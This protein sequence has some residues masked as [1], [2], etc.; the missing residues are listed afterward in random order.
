[1]AITPAE[2]ELVGAA[3]PL[4]IS[5]SLSVGRASWLMAAMI[6]LS[7]LTGF[8]RM[9]LVS[10]LYGNGPQA[11]A[12]EAAFNIPDTITILIAGG[13]LAT[14]FV[15]VFTEYISRGQDAQARRTFRAMW[16]LL[17]TAFGIVT[18]LLFALTW[19]PLGR[20]LAPQKVA[21]QYIDLYLHLLRILLAAQFFFVVGGLF[22]GTLNALRLFW[23][24]AL[25]PV[26]FNGGIIVF[27]V[28]LPYFFHMGI[29]SQAWGALLGA[30]VGSLLIQMPAVLRNG[31]SL[32]PLWDLNDAGVRRVLKSLLPIVFG[33]A[34][35]QIIALNLPRFIAASQLLPADLTSLGYANR[36]MQV[37]LDLL[38]SGPAIAL[39]PTLSLLASQGDLPAMSVQLSS[40]LRRTILLTLA[41][42]ALLAA[43]R[44]PLIH[45]VLEHGQFDKSDTKYTTP[46]LLC[47][48]LCIVG[49]GAQQMMA[50]GFYA[51]GETRPPVVIG[52]GAMML[53]GVLA[54]PLKT[55][56]GASGL[57]LS[58]AIAV[59]ALAVAM[60]I[61]LRARLSGMNG[62]ALGEALWKGAIAAIAAYYAAFY[63]AGFGIQWITSQGLDNADSASSV[64]LAAR[65]IVLVLGAVAGVAIYLLTA[66]LLG[67]RLKGS[68]MSTHAGDGYG[69]RRSAPR[70][71]FGRRPKFVKGYLPPRETPPPT[72]PISKEK[73]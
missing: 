13:A 29:E 58:A 50:R 59:S 34:S 68:H 40:A 14:G 69:T 7:R 42:T 47:Y 62:G 24:P 3:R 8:G 10:H 18:L 5:Q 60:W 16:T 54:W 38:A 57:A 9:M 11:A 25:Q 53:F 51:L 20:S 55:V 22:S 27:G 45:L 35:G 21:P 41:A 61:S 31:L 70:L 48:A 52:I 33:L 23:Y 26:L 2:L 12:F 64:K 37:P 49:L 1:M 6:A 73:P 63:M 46:V 19:T 65:A 15:P 71:P 17:G 30:V 32:K 66:R 56:Y 28:A 39:F 36:L 44:F 43:L 67:L 4:R 72:P